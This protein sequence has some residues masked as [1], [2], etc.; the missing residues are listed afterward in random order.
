MLPAFTGFF[1]RDRPLYFISVFKNL[2]RENENIRAYLV[3]KVFFPYSFHVLISTY[4]YVIL[5]TYS[6]FYEGLEIKEEVS[7]SYITDSQFLIQIYNMMKTCFSFLQFKK[8]TKWKQKHFL[9]V[10]TGP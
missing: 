9:N 4:K 10:K 1:L 3:S 8:K 5:F 2:Y 6:D 7:F